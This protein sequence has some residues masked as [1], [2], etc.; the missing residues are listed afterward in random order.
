MDFP[1]TEEQKALQKPA[2][3]YVA[4]HVRPVAAELDHNR[5]PLL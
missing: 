1:L 5:L 2:R 3:D 4:P